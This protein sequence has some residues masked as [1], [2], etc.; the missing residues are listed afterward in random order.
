MKCLEDLMKYYGVE[1]YNTSTN[2]CLKDAV[3]AQSLRT[4]YSYKDLEQC[5]AHLRKENL[6]D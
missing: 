6:I 4:T 2:V 3:F 5:K 1:P